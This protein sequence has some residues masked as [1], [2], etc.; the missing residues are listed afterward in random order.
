MASKIKR[1]TDEERKIELKAY[2]FAEGLKGFF[3]LNSTGTN[4]VAEVEIDQKEIINTSDTLDSKPITDSIPVSNSRPISNQEPVSNSESILNPVPTPNLIPVLNSVPISDQRPVLDSKPVPNTIP[5]L[6]SGPIK[7][8]KSVLNSEPISNSES[9]F[10]APSVTNPKS[11]EV[12]NSIPVPKTKHIKNNTRIEF[13]INYDNYCIK[14]LKT[15]KTQNKSLA[16]LGMLFLLHSLLPPSGGRIKI[17]RVASATGMG[18]SNILAQLEALENVGLINT[19]AR[20]ISGRLISFG[21]I[22]NEMGI[23]LV[24]IS[25]SSSSLLINN[26][27]NMYTESVTHY[28]NE[29][30]T[31]FVTDTEFVTFREDAKN[32]KPE[33]EESELKNILRNNLISL[34]FSAQEFFFIAKAAKINVARLTNQCFQQYHDLKNKMGDKYT[35]GLFLSLLSKAKDNPT[36][37]VAKAIQQGASASPDDENR[38][39]MV[40]RAG[41]NILKEVGIDILRKDLETALASLSLEGQAQAAIRQEC[42]EFVRKIVVR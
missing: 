25:S 1:L 23:E 40:L 42:D 22:E 6:N 34:K 19:I 14:A 13:D 28:E 9:I 24:T 7:S 26:N 5:V 31:E 18:K 21:G 41:E 27:N 35:N 4:P 10:D 32:I 33:S 15:L 8:V 12:S 37:Y 3:G 30:G 20:D 29:T 38:S 39:E 2:D 11:K 36:A 16:A 17:D